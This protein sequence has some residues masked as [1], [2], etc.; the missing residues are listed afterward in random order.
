MWSSFGQAFRKLISRLLVQE[1][2]GFQRGLNVPPPGHKSSKES[3]AWIV[4]NYMY[5]Y[6]LSNVLYFECSS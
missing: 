1:E 2:H 6:V 5:M 3:L 4:L